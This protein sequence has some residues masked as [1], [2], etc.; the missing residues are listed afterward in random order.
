MAFVKISDLPAGSAV[1]GTD[2]FESSQGTAPTLNSVKVTAS[3]LKTFAAA[4]SVQ[5]SGD[6]MTG[7]LVIN[8]TLSVSGAFTISNY[9]GYLKANGASSATASATIPGADITGNISGSAGNVTGV[10]AAANGGTGQSS[11]TTGDLLVASGATTLSKLAGAATGNALISGGVGAAPTYGKI[12]LTTH[13]SGT[14]P[15][16]NG[17]TGVTASTGTGNVVLSDAP[18]FS[19]VVTFG[20][21]DAI[22]V[23]VGTTA[24]RPAS[25]TGHLRFN[26]TTASFEGY[27]GTAWASVGGGATGGGGDQAFYLNSTTVNNSYSIP[28]GQNAG[29]FGPVTVASGAVVTVPSGSTWTVV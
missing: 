11:Y 10:V 22:T 4:D 13:V 26:S 28:S 2:L 27:N 15:V 19:G 16:A 14:L 5:K 8:S 3:Q 23:P 12:G 21:T 20:G 29:T 17:G 6:T 18:T 1:S 25:A 24:Q 9:T 7:G